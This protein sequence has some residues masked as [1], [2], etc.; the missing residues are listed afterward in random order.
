[1]MPAVGG[2]GRWQ[3]QRSHRVHGCPG[4]PC[5]RHGTSTRLPI[6]WRW[7]GVLFL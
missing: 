6:M 3:A 5:R 2:I 4:D 1:L 7:E